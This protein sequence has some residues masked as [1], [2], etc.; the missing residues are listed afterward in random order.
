MTAGLLSCRKAEGNPGSET[1]QELSE[2][3]QLA[4]QD[5]AATFTSWPD[6][7]QEKLPPCKRL[8]ARELFQPKTRATPPRGYALWVA[9]TPLPSLSLGPVPQGEGRPRTSTPAS[10]LGQHCRSMKTGSCLPGEGDTSTGISTE[11]RREDERPQRS[12]EEEEEV[13]STER[14]L[15]E[16]IRPQCGRRGPADSADGTAEG[17][18]EEGTRC[19]DLEVPPTSSLN[20]CRGRPG[21][22]LADRL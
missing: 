21:K 12:T 3:S 9:G 6:S 7:A 8:K 5:F 16:P 10:A 18:L 11:T 20:S 22:M 15:G 13:R 4:T 17:C 14:G 1:N 19:K 2:S